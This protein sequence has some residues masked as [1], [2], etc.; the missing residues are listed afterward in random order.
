MWDRFVDLA[1]P[2]TDAGAVGQ[3]VVMAIVWIGLIGW[4]RRWRPEY[5]T[6]VVGLAVANFAWFGARMIH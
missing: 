4:S 6:F 2:R 1:L 5:R 3:I